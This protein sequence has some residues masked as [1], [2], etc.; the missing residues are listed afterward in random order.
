MFAFST[1]ERFA[2]LDSKDRD[3]LEALSKL[4]QFEAGRELLV[5][6]QGGEWLYLIV[7]GGVE[8]RA[9]SPAREFVVGQLGPG[10]VFGELE[11]FADLPE[12][13]L[14]YV[15]RSSTIVRA[16]NKHP[17]KQEMKA[18][19]SLA[20]GLLSVYCRSISE[21]VRSANEAAVRLGPYP[22]GASRP[23][24]AYGTK[25][26][27][28]HLSAEEAGWI[29]V[30]GQSLAASEG[31]TVLAEGEVSRA[32]F[33]VEEGE[34]EVRK[35]ADAGPARALARLGPRDLFGFMS[36]VDGK[37]RSASVVAV[38]SC[39]LSRIEPQALQKAAQMNFTVSFKFL[40]TLC[41]VLG[42][43]YRDTVNTV[44]RS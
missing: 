35:R 31:E 5:S 24:P 4:D 3:R 44:L 37:P 27:P 20:A 1:S 19:R 25:D 43:T 41:N 34:L 36:F 38:R 40:G 32:F 7:S 39:T 18:H 42:R 22:A 28:P 21:K 10:D 8:I 13:N 12:G 33:V 6:G 11:A 16:V 23:P 15:A 9:C 30:L 2:A 26:R 29:S 14:R 17:L